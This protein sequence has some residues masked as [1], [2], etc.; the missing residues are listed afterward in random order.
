ML[1][2]WKNLI[3]LSSELKE[4]SYFKSLLN[5]NIL[6]KDA[7]PFSETSLSMYLT[8]QHHSVDDRLLATNII[9]NVNKTIK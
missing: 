7:A 8:T 6:N 1:M 3:K 5:Q 9:A 4:I 2:S